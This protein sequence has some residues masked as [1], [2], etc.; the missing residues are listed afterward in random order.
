MENNIENLKE[1]SKIYEREILS[2]LLNISKSFSDGSIDKE[3]RDELF[4]TIDELR[5]KVRD[6]EKIIS[7]IE[8]RKYDIA[9]KD[10]NGND[11]LNKDEKDEEIKEDKKEISDDNG[12]KLEEIEIL[13]K[14]ENDT[15]D[16]ELNEEVSEDLVINYDM[17]ELSED[18]LKDIDKVIDNMK[19][20]ENTLEENDDENDKELTEDTSNFAESNEESFEESN[21]DISTDIE[22]IDKLIKDAKYLNNDIIK[23]PQ[24]SVRRRNGYSKV[25]DEEDN[26]EKI[27]E[28]STRRRVKLEEDI[29]EKEDIE[30]DNEEIE[31]VP[32]LFGSHSRVQN[33]MVV[34][35][36]SSGFT[37]KLKS[38]VFK[39]KSLLGSDEDDD[40]ED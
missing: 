2:N 18:E 35:K 26:E 34:R 16:D 36:K 6:I 28:V 9:Y 39:I 11:D 33:Q 29:D 12:Y 24:N 32:V 30:L 7:D 8:E 19:K 14:E 4:K 1:E 25:E 20:D 27:E 23:F 10:I 21:D 3:K 38:L 37:T 5:E 13:E 40:E 17:K 22:K 31:K 15:K